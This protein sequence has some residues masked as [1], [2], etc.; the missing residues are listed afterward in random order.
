MKLKT[1]DKSENYA[2]F[3]RQVNIAVSPELLT[4]FKTK[5]ASYDFTDDGCVDGLHVAIH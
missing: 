1:E 5:C 4:A 2:N 3:R